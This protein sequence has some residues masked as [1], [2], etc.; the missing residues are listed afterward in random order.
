[1]SKALLHWLHFSDLEA[2]SI[3]MN[4]LSAKQNNEAQ[5]AKA[6]EPGDLTLLACDLLCI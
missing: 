5:K 1:M 4:S 6:T 3:I 2:T